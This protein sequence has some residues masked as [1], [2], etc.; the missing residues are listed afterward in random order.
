MY[1]GMLGKN[2]IVRCVVQLLNDHTLCKPW[3]LFHLYTAGQSLYDMFVNVRL[4][5]IIT[6][7]PPNILMSEGF[8][9]FQSCSTI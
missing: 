1:Q 2:E 4:S 5:E 3:M 8:G 6:H 9:G 7:R